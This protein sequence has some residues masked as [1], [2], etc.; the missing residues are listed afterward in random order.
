MALLAKVGSRRAAAIGASTGLR[1]PVNLGFTFRQNGDRVHH[2][3]AVVTTLSA[4]I[5]LLNSGEVDVF[6]GGRV[7]TFNCLI[8]VTAFVSQ[9][10]IGTDIGADCSSRFAVTSSK[11]TSVLCVLRLF[12]LLRSDVNLTVDQRRTAMVID[13]GRDKVVRGCDPLENLYRVRLFDCSVH[14]CLG[15]RMILII[16]VWLR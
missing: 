9:V 15:I 10:T 16:L 5:S 3:T 4:Q 7:V 6:R 13:T 12:L 1:G 14:R 11:I 8:V 2:P